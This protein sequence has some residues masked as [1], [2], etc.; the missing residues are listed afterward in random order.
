MFDN[1]NR[2]LCKPISFFSIIIISVLILI[3]ASNYSVY[4]EVLEYNGSQTLYPDHYGRQSFFSRN[5]LVDNIVTVRANLESAY[6]GL[7][8]L[9]TNGNRTV[10]DN[11]LTIT[12]LATVDFD[13]SGGH[14]YISSS[15][16]MS[17]ATTT[18][19]VLKIE[20]NSTVSGNATGGH[21]TL[22]CGSYTGNCGRAI[23]S[24]N[25]VYVESTTLGTV[26]TYGGYVK[27]Q[28]AGSSEISHNTVTFTNVTSSGYVYAAYS[29]IT[30]N[31]DVIAERN[32]LN[33]V[34]STNTGSSYGEDLHGAYV[35]II[36]DGNITINNNILKVEQNSTINLSVYAADTLLE[37]SGNI[38]ASSNIIY[39]MNSTVSDA[40]QA[41]LAN[42]NEDGAA[43]A[44]DN[45][46]ILENAT[47]GGSLTVGEATVDEDGNVEALRNIITSSGTNTVIY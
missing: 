19:N 31:G 21:V 8:R 9:T 13:A 38:E 45:Q 17:E 43:N 42:I 39:I 33:F 30:L 28:G 1:V 40:V 46:V 44:N 4:A 27:I 10:K 15:G 2:I 34:N 32:E 47:V 11:K 37:G 3:L 36:E 26:K 24:D 22:N 35:H 20:T 25:D 18:G 14:I 7:A 29:D 16:G 41:A 6:G 23:A 12:N 5:D